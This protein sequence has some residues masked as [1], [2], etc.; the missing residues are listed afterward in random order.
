MNRRADD[1][2]VLRAIPEEL[3]AIPEFE[4]KVVA[5][6]VFSTDEEEAFW[7]ADFISPPAGAN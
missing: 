3:T 6:H 1:N 5:S 7:K 2:E 4:N